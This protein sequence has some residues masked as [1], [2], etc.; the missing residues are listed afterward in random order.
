MEFEDQCA[1]RELEQ[2]LVEL[3]RETPTEGFAVGAG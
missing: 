2:M 1:D 3:S